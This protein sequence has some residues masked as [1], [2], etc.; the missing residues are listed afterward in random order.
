MSKI[1]ISW[2]LVMKWQVFLTKKASKQ[3]RKL[4]IAI[5]AA[6]RLLVEDLILQGPAVDWPNYN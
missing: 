5:L 4:N 2:E 1:D 6:L 3:A